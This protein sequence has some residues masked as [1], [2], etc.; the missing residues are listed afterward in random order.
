MVFSMILQTG[1]VNKQFQKLLMKCIHEILVRHTEMLDYF[2]IMSKIE[3][4]HILAPAPIV[5]PSPAPNQ[6]NPTPA[7][8]F[9][10]CKEIDY[11]Q[12]LIIV[13]SNGCYLNNI[14]VYERYVDVEI[15]QHT[16]GTLEIYLN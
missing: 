9:S 11:D 2:N 6:N 8:T 3:F 14:T 10:S 15:I 4:V 7:P 5:N 1:N 12:S 16:L 13:V